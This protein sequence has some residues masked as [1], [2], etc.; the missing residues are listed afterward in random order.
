MELQKELDVLQIEC[1]FNKDLHS[2]VEAMKDV[3]RSFCRNTHTGRKSKREK[4]QTMTD[5]SKHSRSYPKSSTAGSPEIQNTLHQK[6]NR[7]KMRFQGI[8]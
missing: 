4:I 5:D 8:R 2:V 1:Y 7:T 6:G 3:V